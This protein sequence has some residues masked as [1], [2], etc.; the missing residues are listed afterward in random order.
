MRLVLALSGGGREE[1]YPAA[2]PRAHRPKGSSTISCRRSPCA[3][4]LTIAPGLGLAPHER[5]RDRAERAGRRR[6]S[7]AADRA[8]ASVQLLARCSPARRA[9]ARADGGWAAPVI[10]ARDRLLADVAALREAHRALVQ[11]GLLGDR[12]LVDV[13]PVAGAPALDRA[14]TPRPARRPRAPRASSAAVSALGARRS[15]R[16]RRRHPCE[17]RAPAMPSI[18]DRR[19]RVLL[20]GKPSRAGDLV[21]ERADQRKQRALERAL[22]QFDLVADLEAADHVEQGLE[23]R[24]LGVEQQL[25]RAAG[26]G[27][28]RIRTS[29]SILPLCVR[30][31]A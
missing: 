29:P 19:V 24:A 18:C 3:P 9:A 11:A 5:E 28:A 7:R 17:P 14:R 2:A 23:R 1:S 30:N 12:G 31:A 4:T 20:A 21:G 25:R 22:V 16:G 26:A 27:G 10:E 13:D 6:R 8:P 15:A